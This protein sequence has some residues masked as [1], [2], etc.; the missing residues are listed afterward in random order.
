MV[1]E[2]VTFLKNL[3]LDEAG[4]AADK[5]FINA[6]NFHEAYSASKETFPIEK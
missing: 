5:L 1:E 3:P 4:F 2:T 6:T